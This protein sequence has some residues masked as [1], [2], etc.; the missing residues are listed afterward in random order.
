[1]D[2]TLCHD[3]TLVDD[4]LTAGTNQLNAGGVLD[5]AALMN[6]G[7]DAEGT[8]IGK[9]NLDLIIGAAGAENAHLERALGADDLNLFLAGEL[10]G[11]AEI[12]FEG[13]LSA[14]AEEGL[15]ILLGKMD[16]SCRGF[17]DKGVHFI[18]PFFGRFAALLKYLKYRINRWLI[19]NTLL[20]HAFL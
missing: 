10:T 2:V 4:N 14:L 12:L 13:E 20:Y 5:I 16:M 11:L 7:S 6:G 15:E 8:G 18:F 17:Y 9:R 1:M 19:T 3:Y